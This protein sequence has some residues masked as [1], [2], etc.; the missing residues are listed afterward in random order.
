M[1]PVHGPAR[2]G[3]YGQRGLIYRDLAVLARFRY[4]QRQGEESHDEAVARRARLSR[5]SRLD[6]GVYFE[7]AGDALFCGDTLFAGYRIR[8]DIRGHQEIGGLFGCRVIPLEL[9]DPYYY[10]LDTCFC[11]LAPGMAIY[12]PGGLRRLWP[13]T[14]SAERSPI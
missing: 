3:L 13:A 4:P 14:C 12:Y 2:P 9:V 10:H 5:C 7:G 6:A 8:S 11:P 1:T